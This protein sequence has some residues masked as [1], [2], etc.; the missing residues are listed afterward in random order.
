[1]RKMFEHSRGDHLMVLNAVR[2]YEVV[3]AGEGQN[4]QYGSNSG[5]KWKQREWC[6]KHFLNERT[7]IEARDIREQL[8]RTCKRVGLDPSA[9]V[10]KEEEEAEAV[11]RSLGHGL[12]G[13]SALLQPDGSYKQTIG[14][15]VNLLSFFFFSPLTHHAI[16]FFL[17]C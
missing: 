10:K 8:V 16:D 9:S 4:H 14:Q 12:V 5:N 15:R 3:R 13:N 2:A 11:M 17:D 6:H 1:V 7:F